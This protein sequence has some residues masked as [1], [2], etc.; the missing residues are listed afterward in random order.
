MC[1][2][3]VLF[4]Q[5]VGLAPAVQSAVGEKHSEFSGVRAE[6]KSPSALVR[7]TVVAAGPAVTTLILAAEPITD[8][9]STAVDDLAELDDFLANAGITFIIAEMKGSVKDRLAS[10]GLDRRFGPERFAPT[11]GAAVDAVLGHE[12][13]DIGEPSDRS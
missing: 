4:S 11:V 13:D 9:D 5:Y 6:L 8:I 7:S 12:R 10:Y 3:A 2:L 1:K